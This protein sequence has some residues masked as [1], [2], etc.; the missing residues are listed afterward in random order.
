M[1]H[2]IIGTFLIVILLQSCSNT[3]KVKTDSK[4]ET[5]TETETFWVSGYKT[6]V[7]AG[8]GKIESFLINKNDNYAEGNWQN[9]Y[10]S[11]KGFNFE[12]GYLKKIK[13]SKTE[14][15]NGKVP[16]D[17]SSISYTFKEELDKKPD[18]RNLIE[19][20]WTLVKINGNPINKSVSIPTLNF[21][22]KNMR[23][24]GNDGCNNYSGS[25][26]SLGTKN[27]NLGMMVSTKKACINDNISTDYY[28]AIE[29]VN[30][31]KVENNHLQLF[32]N[33]VEVLHFLKTE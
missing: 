30:N 6:E 20:N 27:V 24:S 32:E 26:K 21:S 5:E 13:V 18:N 23:V 4:A 31:F 9:F 28:K 17:A 11:I 8:A 22:L 7:S 33:G 19:G 10:T 16:A 1:K 14:I 29:K 15:E 12:E 25:V 2:K 3:K